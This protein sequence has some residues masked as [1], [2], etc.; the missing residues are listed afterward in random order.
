VNYP[1]AHLAIL[2][3]KKQIWI[4]FPTSGNEWCNQSLVFDIKSSNFGAVTF[5][6]PIS[7]MA[8]GILN[9]DIVG[10][11]YD[12]RIGDYDSAQDRYNTALYNPTTDLLAFS[13]FDPATFFAVD[14]FLREGAPVPVYVQL[15][16]K[17]MGETQ[18]L[19]VIQAVWPLA[20]SGGIVNGSLAVRV[21]VQEGINDPISWTAATYTDDG[22][23]ADLMTTGRYI[24]L[25]L[26]GQQNGAWRLNS[27]DVDYELGGMW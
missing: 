19:K 13:I 3:S 8:R 6:T 12:G 20:Q 1:A 16:S 15:L 7:F 17:D 4:N 21:G 9:V 22:L 27:T 10:N 2:H 14:G 18:Q 5:P 25:E 23:K 11:T 24:S 26:S